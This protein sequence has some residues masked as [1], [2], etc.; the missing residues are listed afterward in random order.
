MIRY[1]LAAAGAA[2]IGCFAAS[3]QDVEFQGIWHQE[4]GISRHTG[5]LPLDDFI[6]AGEQLVTDGLRLTDVETVRIQG[7]RRY[8]GLFTE[9]S[10]GNFIDVVTGRS[11]LQ[12]RMRVRAEQGLRVTD[13][14]LFGPASDRTFVIVTRPGAGGQRITRPLRFVDFLE[15]KEL[16]RTLGLRL[17]DLEVRRLG[18]RLRYVGLFRSDQPPAV[19][20]G[21]RSRAQLTQL[22]DRMVSRGWE[23][24]DV[25]RQQNAAGDDIY[26]GVWRR[27]DGA[28]RLSL[29]RPL[30]DQLAFA[31][32]QQQSGRREVDFELKRNSNPSDPNPDPGPDPEPD[33]DPTPIPDYLTVSSGF[34]QDT[35]RVEFTGQPDI[36]FTIEFPFSWLPDEAVNNEGEIVLPAQW[37]RLT[38]R[39]ADR[40][41]WQ[42]PGDPAVETPFFNAL[43]EVPEEFHLGGLSFGGPFGTCEGTQTPWVFDLP[44]TSEQLPFEPLPN[45]SLV[46]QAAGGEISFE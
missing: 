25:E 41:F 13:V 43:P 2:C 44:L 26:F 23:L 45:M 17:A 14:E 7:A 40:A 6:E 31:N 21:A 18:G 29:F 24:F 33:P 36:P 9:G 30:L 19:I 35:L 28:S 39:L 46:I 42:V 22:R 37:C 1:F 5:F 4:D 20:T 27:G 15:Q 3:A 11:A 32:D 12:A 34:G 16:F 38:V 8:T 10:G